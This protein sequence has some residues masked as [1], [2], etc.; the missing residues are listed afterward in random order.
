M[1]N[2]RSLP[3][4][5]TFL[6]AK[7]I[8]SSVR[9]HGLIT[10]PLLQI[11]TAMQSRLKSSLQIWEIQ[12]TPKFLA[13]GTTGVYEWSPYLTVSGAAVRESVARWQRSGFYS[14]TSER[15]VCLIKVSSSGFITVMSATFCG[16][17]NYSNHFGLIM[18][19]F[20]SQRCIQATGLQ[21]VLRV[22]TEA[23]RLSAI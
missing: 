5:C 14:S 10:F 15:H 21:I 23:L 3:Y 17:F 19:Y 20:T 9:R 6:W 8:H 18:S 16:P 11:T 4:R 1:I 2:P 7:Y 12:F 13:S 22:Y